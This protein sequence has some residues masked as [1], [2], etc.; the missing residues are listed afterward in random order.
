MRDSSLGLE[1]VGNI[2]HKRNLRLLGEVVIG[3]VHV[4]RQVAAIGVVFTSLK[5]T[6]R[7]GMFEANLWADHDQPVGPICNSDGIFIV[8]G[9]ITRPGTATIVPPF[10]AEG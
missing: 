7:E 9:G 10:V 6:M 2:H 3:S 4:K 8:S 1:V 5:T